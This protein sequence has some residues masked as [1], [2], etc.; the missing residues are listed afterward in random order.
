VSIAPRTTRVRWACDPKTLTDC[1][2]A[3]ALDEDDGRRAGRAGRPAIGFA[4]AL[5]R[6]IVR[7]ELGAI[8][9]RAAQPLVRPI[10]QL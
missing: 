3:H 5:H 4:Y 8:C 1:A 6:G 7:A 10:G 9:R 2:S